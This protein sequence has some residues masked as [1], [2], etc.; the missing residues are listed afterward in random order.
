MLSSERSHPY[1]N[2]SAEDYDAEPDGLIGLTVQPGYVDGEAVTNPNTGKRAR[3]HRL[4][5]ST[6]SGPSH[7][8]TDDNDSDFVDLG[9]CDCAWCYST[10]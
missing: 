4:F 7:M 8:F 10:D 6:I 2:M 9:H 1:S 3:D 5:T